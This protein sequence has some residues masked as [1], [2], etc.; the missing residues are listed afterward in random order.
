MVKTK[1]KKGLSELQT[2]YEQGK[3]SKR[4]YDLIINTYYNSQTHL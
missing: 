4:A 3:L 2:Y 1:T